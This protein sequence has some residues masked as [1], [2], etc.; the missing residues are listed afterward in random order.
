MPAPQPPAQLSID[1]AVSE[2]PLSLMAPVSTFCV[3]LTGGSCLHG[4]NWKIFLQYV[5]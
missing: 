3:P 5:N 2:M 1:L 4:V